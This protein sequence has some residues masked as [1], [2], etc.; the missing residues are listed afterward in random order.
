MFRIYIYYKNIK[1]LNNFD[2][3]LFDLL[4]FI[5]LLCICYLL[6]YYIFVNKLQY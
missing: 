4:L 6:N 5:K 3:L 2:L 1:K